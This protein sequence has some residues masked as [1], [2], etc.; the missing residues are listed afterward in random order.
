MVPQVFKNQFTKRQHNLGPSGVTYAMNTT[1]G[2]KTNVNGHTVFTGVLPHR[3]P[4]L[5]T[6]FSKAMMLFWRFVLLSVP[7]HECACSGGA[8]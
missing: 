2:G 3:N 8:S 4:L 7:K 6:M 5:C 1:N